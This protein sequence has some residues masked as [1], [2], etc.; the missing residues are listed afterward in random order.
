VLPSAASNDPTGKQLVAGNAHACSLEPKTSGLLCWGDN[1]FGQATVPAFLSPNFVAAGGDVTCAITNDIVSC[2]GDPSHG[3]L[4]VPFGL[5]NPIQLAV[6]AAHVCALTADGTV[7]CWGDNAYGQL[8]APRLDNVRAIAAGARHSCALTDRG[9][10]CWGDN[11][12]S[13]LAVPTLQAPLQLAVGAFH[14][15][16]IDAGKVVCWGGKTSALL[17]GIPQ[18]SGPTAIAAG[19]DHSCVVDAQG[20]Q[21]W[22]DPATTDLKPRELTE[23]TQLTVG[24]GAGRAYACARHLQGVACWGDASLHQTSYDGGPLHVLHRSESFIAA[25]AAK[26]WGVI[27]DLDH[28]PDWNPYTIAMKSTLQ[29]GDAMAMTVKMSATQTIQ[30]TEYIRVLEA[31]HKACW[32]IDTTSPEANSGER[33]Q[34]LETMPDGSTHY[35][36]EDLIEGTLNPIV[37]LLFGNDV[38]VGFDAV[39]S[40]LK[41]R[42]ES[43]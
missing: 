3:Q 20:V 19:A 7:H 8:S 13:Q 38:Q 9:V 15:C 10:T 11:S 2:W 21:C 39:A 28:Y 6:G 33:C 34:W 27:V 24:G 40:A 32:G 5:L 22:G 16:V 29:V 12:Q 42:V 43:L 4:L 30:Q 36:T 23:V 26:V 31:G 14:N 37:T 35:I 41:T 17:A 25:P 18:V 1:R